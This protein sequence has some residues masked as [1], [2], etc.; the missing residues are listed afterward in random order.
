MECERKIM[1]PALSQVIVFWLLVTFWI[2]GDPGN[3]E[4]EDDT[5]ERRKQEFSGAEQKETVLAS[6]E[7]EDKIFVAMK[8]EC[9]KEI[10]W[11]LHGSIPN[12]FWRRWLMDILLYSE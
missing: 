2:L 7:T 6:Y 8:P 11:K 3:L 4:E 5:E 1:K 12:F 9:L 10:C